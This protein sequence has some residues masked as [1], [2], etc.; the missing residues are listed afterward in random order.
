MTI[1]SVVTR[2]FESIK[3]RI[4]SNGITQPVGKS[5]A[6]TVVY[7]ENLMGRG[8]RAKILVKSCAV[9]VR[10]TKVE[11]GSVGY[12]DAILQAACGQG[13]GVPGGHTQKYSIGEA[14]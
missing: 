7:S 11:G 10:K 5:F 12:W 2:I 3:C 13:Y 8:Q 1:F 6:S 4:W 9:T 14:S